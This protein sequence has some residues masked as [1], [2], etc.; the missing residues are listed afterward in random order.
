MAALVGDELKVFR[1]LENLVDRLDPGKGLASGGNG[2]P[3][4]IGSG[5]LFLWGSWVQYPLGLEGPGGLA[6]EGQAGGWPGAGLQQGD[7]RESLRGLVEQASPV[8]EGTES[9]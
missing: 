2:E 9:R 4:G 7:A 5:F 6:V 3:A 8:R 1:G